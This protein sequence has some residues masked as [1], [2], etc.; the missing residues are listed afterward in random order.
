M[1][2]TQGTASVLAEPKKPSDL[3]TV[4]EGAV[5]SR[6]LIDRP[7]GTVTLFAFDKDQGL[8]EHHAPYDALVEV[9]D[10]EVEVTVSGRPYRMQAGD[11][12]LIPAQAAHALRAE[13]PMKMLLTMV[14][15]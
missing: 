1:A 2:Q 6:T 5:V 12:L 3:L 7:T 9:L 8:S 10:G 11:F 4:Q 15:S 14:R 13:S